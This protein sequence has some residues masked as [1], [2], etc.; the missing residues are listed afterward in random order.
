MYKIKLPNRIVYTD[1][2]HYVSFNLLTF[3]YTKCLE[4]DAEA[5]CIHNE[6]F[7]LPDKPPVHHTELK[8]IAEGVF[9][10]TAVTAPV[11]EISELSDSD[12]MDEITSLKVR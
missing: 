10:E 3:S 2:I 9:V 5:I 4:K 11:A 8:Q 12:Y 6:I 7:S 1:S